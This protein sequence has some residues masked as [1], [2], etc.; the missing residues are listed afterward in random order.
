MYRGSRE[1]GSYP[2]IIV[3]VVI[4]IEIEIGRIE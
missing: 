4:S 1:V 2:V 3:I